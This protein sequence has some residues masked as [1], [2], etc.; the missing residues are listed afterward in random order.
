MMVTPEH[1]SRIC[2][3]DATHIADL[4]EIGNETNLSPWSADSYLEEIKNPNAI[5]LRL[6]SD[7][8]ETMGFVVGRVVMGGNI[9][10]RPD[11]EI[12][13][14]AISGDYQ[15][16]GY[17]Q[18]LLDRFM[19]EVT[20]HRVHNVWLEVRE[21]NKRAIDLYSRNGFEKVQTR[22]NFYQNP[23]EAALLMRLRIPGK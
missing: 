6:V 12:Y 22:P 7:D 18:K 16:N 17:G 2:R 9:E 8:N 1:G 4:I 10:S 11:A 21:S 3:V 15:G 20:A 23:R 5:M 14:I 19:S 13:N